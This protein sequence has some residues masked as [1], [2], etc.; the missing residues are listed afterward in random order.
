MERHIKTLGIIYIV[1]GAFGIVGALL[2][3][4]GVTGVGLLTENKETILIATSAATV[5]AVILALIS[6]L[7]I[8]GG[9]GLLRQRSWARVL[10]IMLGCL[11]LISFPIG[12]VVGIYTLWAL[13]RPESPGTLS[14]G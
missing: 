8:I 4:I 1:L 5:V 2:L 3:S 11:Y 14:P 6:I 9:A 12:T 10:V 7:A 13:T